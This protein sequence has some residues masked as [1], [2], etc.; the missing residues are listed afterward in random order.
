MDLKSGFT[1]KAWYSMAVGDGDHKNKQGYVTSIFN[2]FRDIK[3]GKLT[4]NI[5]DKKQVNPSS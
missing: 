3:L 2:Q 5:Q 4:P 1:L